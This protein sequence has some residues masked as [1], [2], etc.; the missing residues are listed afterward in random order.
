MQTT[1]SVACKIITD[2]TV[3]FTEPNIRQNFPF[4]CEKRGKQTV[5]QSA[6]EFRKST[7]TKNAECGEGLVP[8]PSLAPELIFIKIKYKGIYPYFSKV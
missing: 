3:L 8:S 7:A 2:F 6:K 5:V 1:P 4:F